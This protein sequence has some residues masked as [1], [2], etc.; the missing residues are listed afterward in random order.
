MQISEFRRIKDQLQAIFD[1][2]DTKLK[3][4]ITI[5]DSGIVT[6]ANIDVEYRT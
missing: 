5:D 4:S 2:E 1:A 6:Y 3:W